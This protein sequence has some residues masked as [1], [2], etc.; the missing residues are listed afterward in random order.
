MPA[1]SEM[2]DA[3]KRLHGHSENKERYVKA[4]R[5]IRELTIDRAYT[6]REELDGCKSQVEHDALMIDWGA[7]AG[8]DTGALKDDLAWTSRIKEH[9]LRGVFTAERIEAHEWQRRIGVSHLRRIGKAFNV[10][11]GELLTSQERAKLVLDTYHANWTVKELEAEL[12]RQ[13]LRKPAK[14]RSKLLPP[15]QSPT[16]AAQILRVLADHIE[17]EGIDSDLYHALAKRGEGPINIG[18]FLEWLGAEYRR[19]MPRAAFTL[20]GGAR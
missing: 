19:D 16:R 7:E 15:I 20:G 3:E 8:R 1:L 13:K 9:E 18:A 6:L 5:F 17:A 4:T 14:K 11:T 10:E 12:V 2:T